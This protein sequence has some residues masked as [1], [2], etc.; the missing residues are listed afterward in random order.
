MWV[1]FCLTTILYSVEIPLINVAIYR[2]IYPVAAMLYFILGY[3]RAHNWHIQRT[4][5]IWNTVLCYIFIAF[6][7]L[8]LAVLNGTLVYSWSY[9]W[10]MVCF[11]C[12]VYVISCFFRNP[13]KE[14]LGLGFVFLFSSLVALSGIYES[15]T[16]NYYHLTHISYLHRKNMFGLYRPNTIFYNVNDSAVFMC[17][18]LVLAYFFAERCT[19][20]GGLIRL[21]S[22]A[23]YGGNILLTESRGAL[24]GAVI[25]LY[26]YYVLYKNVKKRV[27]LVIMLLPVILSGVIWLASIFDVSDFNLEDMGGRGIVWRKSLHN[28]WGSFLLG[29]GPGMTRVL[30]ATTDTFG[31]GVS[32]IHS[33]FLEVL[34]DYGLPGGGAL[35][36][37]YGHLLVR[38][39][40][41]KNFH[42]N[43]LISLAALVAFIPVSVSSSSLLGKV[44]VLCFFGVLIAEVNNADRDVLN[45]SKRDILFM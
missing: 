1:I 32:D 44:W 8:L 37:W 30:N 39:R 24:F 14:K 18:M 26:I 22:L 7:G 31:A 42:K 3:G 5:P 4:S 13:Q 20:R 6:C 19:K 36:I 41:R 33:F 25:F 16:G 43:F 10:Y 29:T 40:K 17:M 21:I 15:V 12:V 35:I 45:M 27:V 23:H 2:V 11:A 34:C 9:I 38:S 28:L